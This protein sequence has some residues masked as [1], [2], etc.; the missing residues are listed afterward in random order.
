MRARMLWAAVVAVAYVVPL[1]AQA[2]AKPVE[3]PPGGYQ[4]D[5][6]IQT[7]TKL[8]YEPTV[9]GT[10][11]DRCWISLN[12][13][14][15]RTTVAFTVTSDRSTVWFDC[16]LSTIAFPAQ[17][18]AKA[19]RQLLDENER[20]GPT[21][22]TYDTGEKRFHLYHAHANRDWTPKRLRQEI[23][24][25][26]DLLRK[27]EPIWRIDNFLR[28][29]R[30]PEAVEAP[31]RATMQGTWK[32]V[33]G[34]QTGTVTPPDQLAKANVIVTIRGN[35]LTAEAQKLEWTFFL[36]PSRQPKAA[37][38]IG[39]TTDRVE[40]GIYKLEGDTLTI[41]LSSPGQERPANFTVPEGDKRSILVLKRQ[42]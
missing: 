42:P 19:M 14:N 25:F 33:E 27:K 16:P 5:E 8:G 34:C 32:L 17:A 20:I 6:L 35:K 38:F 15:Y 23:E 2:P 39:S 9:Y 11:K 36:D 4:P 21:H 22:F 30:V 10:N 3:P 24:R 28:L 29:A 26:D 40:A 1:A 13:G 18:P 12:R 37:D 7:L 31:E 41:H